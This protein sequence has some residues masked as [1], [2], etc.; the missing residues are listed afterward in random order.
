MYVYTHPASVHYH[1]YFVY[2]P[3]AE[4]SSDVSSLQVDLFSR[5]SVG[6]Y[7]N[8]KQTLVTL[9]DSIIHI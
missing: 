3:C 6:V 5:R 8:N 4:V 2:S 7:L 1:S 9:V